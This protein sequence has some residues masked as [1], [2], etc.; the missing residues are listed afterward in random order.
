[1][2]VSE[3]A[4]WFIALIIFCPAGR[5]Y[6]DRSGGKGEPAGELARGQRPHSSG[7]G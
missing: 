2:F 3:I 4:L 7:C 5:E 6:D 1:M